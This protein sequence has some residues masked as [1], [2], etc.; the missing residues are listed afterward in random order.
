ML[1]STSSHISPYLLIS[2]HISPQ[3][4]VK[5]A[6]LD[7]F[8]HLLRWHHTEVQWEWGERRSCALGG[9]SHRSHAPLAALSPSAALSAALGSRPALAPSQVPLPPGRDRY[10]PLSPHISPYLRYLIRLDEIDDVASNSDVLNL[11]TRVDA[12]EQTALMIDDSFMGRFI[13][14]LFQDK[15]RK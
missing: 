14:Q 11:V 6:R 1:A 4:A 15:W 12:D 10:L 7:V 3:L 2:P 13:W 9:R 8:R 5:L